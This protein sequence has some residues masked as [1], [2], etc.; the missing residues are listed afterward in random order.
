MLITSLQNPKLK[1][2]VKWRDRRDRDRAQVV[3][4]E[5]YRALSRALAAGFPVHEV[6]YSPAH[7]LDTNEPEL[8]ARLEGQGAQ[9]VEVAPEPFAK[10]TYRDRPEGLLGI[11]HQTHRTLA[12]IPQ[13]DTPAFLLVAEQIEKPGNLGTMLRSAD[14]AGV[15]ALVLCDP[16]TDLWNPNVVRASTGVL[17]SMPI[18]ECSSREALAYLKGNGIRIVATTPHAEKLFTEVDLTGPV[19]MVVGS[20]QVGLSSQWMDNA[21]LLVRL[22]MMGAADSLNVATATTIALYEALRQR[23]AAGVVTVP[24]PAPDECQRAY[25]P[26]DYENL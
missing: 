1:Q 8:L 7:Y 18:P 2:V 23:I 11:G 3:L 26:P 13:R 25:N 5:G 9:L 17:F 4:L 16:R 14:A 21:D 12:V 22:P 6:F 20:E 19:A 15:D 24:A 10:M